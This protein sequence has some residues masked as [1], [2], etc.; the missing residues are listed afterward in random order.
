MWRDLER[1]IFLVIGK[2]NIA[3]LTTRD[4]LLP[5]KEVEQ[6]GHL[7]VASRLQQRITGIMRYAVQIDITD[8]NP[9]QDLA[10][11]IITRKATHRP[12]LTL[13]RL[14]EFLQ[15]IE[16]HKGRLL[17][18]LTL[19]LSLY[20]FIRSSEL[21]FARWSEIDLEKELW[22]IPA[23]RE[24]LKGSNILIGVQKCAPSIWCHFQDRL[25]PYWKKFGS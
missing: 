20:V 3:D 9:A 1:N 21:R 17:T 15:R 6:S 8:R 14:P 11:T 5:M 16:I 18:R 19:R 25:W 2:R 22:T 12:A 4:L 10:G 7:D 13:E 24:R 23:E